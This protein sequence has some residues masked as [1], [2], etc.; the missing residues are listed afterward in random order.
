[1]TIALAVEPFAKVSVVPIVFVA[2]SQEQGS[3]LNTASRPASALSFGKGTPITPVDETNMEP[4]SHPRCAATLDVMASTASSP[5]RPVNAL[6]LPAFTTKA[7]ALPP[8]ILLRHNSTSEEQQIFCVVTP[9]T[10]VPSDSSIY[11]RS[12]RPQSLYPARAI[13]AV[14][15]AITGASGKGRA[16]GDF[17]DNSRIFH[18]KSGY[19]KSNSMRELRIHL[20]PAALAVIACETNIETTTNAPEC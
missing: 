5:R 8:L 1:L 10:V 14:A 17:T 4:E 11:V 15:P 7:R 18:Y 2:S 16:K 20:W 3:A 6:L 19:G 9:A 13:R 12:H